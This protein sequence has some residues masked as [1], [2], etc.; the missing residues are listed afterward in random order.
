VTASSQTILFALLGG[1]LPALFWLWFWLREDK[2]RP[3]PRGLLF[4]SF[5]IGMIVVPI[6]IPFQRWVSTDLANIGF[7]TIFLWAAIEEIFKYTASYWVA[8]KRKVMDEPIDAMIYLITTAL[9][10]AA[11]ENT[12]FLINSLSSGLFW[13][14]II[15]GNMR[16]IGATLLHTLSSGLVGIAIGL[17]F[18]K[19]KKIRRFSLL[20]GIILS[21]ALH[22]FF[23]F[24]IIS[25][26]SNGVFAVFAVIW[27]LVVFLIL[28]FERVKRVTKKNK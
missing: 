5:I 23:N 21:I 19:S 28:F 7:I 22:T 9:G 15:T 24:F 12:L 8:L 20:I 25:S 10:F 6:V 1:I 4:L 16:F 13:S 2:L 3:E 11:V 26:T 17:S 27:A 14:S 18:Y